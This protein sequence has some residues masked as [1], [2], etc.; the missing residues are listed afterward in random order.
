ME[1]IVSSIAK[2]GPLSFIAIYAIAPFCGIPTLPLNLWAGHFFGLWL[3][4]TYAV[5]GALLGSLLGFWAAKIPLPKVFPLFSSHK[6]LPMRAVVERVK[7]MLAL[8]WNWQSIFLLRLNPLLPP[9]LLGFFYG[10]TPVKPVSFTTATLCGSI[11]PT[12]IVAWAGNA[13]IIGIPAILL[14]LLWKK[15]R[16]CPN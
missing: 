9:P 8:D 3:G 15:F 7:A 12:F 6:A 5:C 10:K 1:T 2:T 4:T 11:A 13:W 14:W 16:K